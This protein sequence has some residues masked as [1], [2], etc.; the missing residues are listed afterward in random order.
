MLGGEEK[1]EGLA[2]QTLQDSGRPS[3]SPLCPNFYDFITILFTFN[4]DNKSRISKKKI[5]LI[6][7]LKYLNTKA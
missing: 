7:W 3:L 6:Q 1:R 5:S 2:L 4:L